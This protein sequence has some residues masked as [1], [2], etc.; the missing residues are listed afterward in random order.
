M[1][2]RN[3]IANDPE[4]LGE[5]EKWLDDSIHLGKGKRGFE[6][7]AD[8]INAAYLTAF[9]CSDKSGF[10]TGQMIGVD[11]GMTFPR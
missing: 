11:G 8:A 10:I 1:I 2:G 4:A 7:Q 5:F 9:L 3:E 6:K